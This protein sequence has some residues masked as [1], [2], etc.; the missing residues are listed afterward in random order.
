METVE[1][2]IINPQAK[3]LLLDLEALNLITVKEKE[4]KLRKLIEEFRKNPDSDMTF[5]EI[6]AEVETVRAERYARQQSQNC[7]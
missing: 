6:T 7:Y 5:E 4:Y 1:V 3:Q 2:K